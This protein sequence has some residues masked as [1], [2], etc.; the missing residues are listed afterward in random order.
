MNTKTWYAILLMGL[1]LVVENQSS[2]M[3]KTVSAK[4]S[5]QECLKNHIGL[6]DYQTYKILMAQYRCYGKHEMPKIADSCIKSIPVVEQH[7]PLVELSNTSDGDLNDKI[8]IMDGCEPS[9]FVNNKYTRINM[10]SDQEFINIYDPKHPSNTINAVKNNP[11][12]AGCCKMRE[13]VF[14]VLE[15][16]LDELDRLAPRFGYQT[17]ELGIKVFEGL[18]DLETQKKLFEGAEASVRLQHPEWMQDRIEQEASKSVCPPDKKPPHSTGAAIDF[19]LFNVKTGESLDLG[20]FNHT[21]DHMDMF[22]DN[23]TAEQQNNRLLLMIAA[24]NA[25]LVNYS[26]EYW[27]WSLNDQ[28]AVYWKQL[29]GQT[30]TCACYDSL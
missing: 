28:W 9:I 2:V 21:S 26:Y 23:V 6:M 1:A 20:D 11:R 19:T 7:E 5:W 15:K 25:G 14:K 10:M 18:R 29:T 16:V 22:S 13:C 8:T 12:S 17:E 30:D 24:T 27:H 3:S 4:Y